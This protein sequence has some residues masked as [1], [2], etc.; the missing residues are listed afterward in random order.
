M[1]TLRLMLCVPIAG[2]LLA[3]P[4]WAQTYKWK[5]A[6]GNTHYTGTPP[7]P[8]ARSVTEKKLQPSVVEQGASYAEREAM[9]T[10]PVTLWLGNECDALCESALAFLK[11]RGIA[12]TEQRIITDEQKDAFVKRF[13]L[14]EARVPAINAGKDHLIGFSASAWTTL[15][16]R[17]G[18][19]AKG[20]ARVAP[21]TPAAAPGPAAA[22]G[23]PADDGNWQPAG[24]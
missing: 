6:Q 12:Y 19:P 11:N 22:N 2:A 23:E 7:P 10:A 1:T 20:T 16:N 15:L 13:K 3:S 21:S 8:D 14:Q 17:A 18:Y 9:R 4:V 5:D 24:Q